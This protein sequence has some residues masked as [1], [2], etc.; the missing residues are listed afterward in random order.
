MIK[1]LLSFS[2]FFKKKL[3]QLK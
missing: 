3:L 1:V 2:N